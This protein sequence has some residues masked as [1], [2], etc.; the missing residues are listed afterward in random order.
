MNIDFSFIKTYCQVSPDDADNLVIDVPAT[1]LLDHTKTEQLLQRL[2]TLYQAHDLLLPVS[3]VGLSLFGLLGTQ[4]IILSQYKKSLHLPL[5]T[6]RLQVGLFNETTPFVSL[7]IQ[8]VIV[9]EP[10]NLVEYVHEQLATPIENIAAAGGVKSSLIYNQFSARAATLVEGFMQYETN[11]TAQTTCK[12]IYRE[13]KEDS[14]WRKNPFLHDPVFID[15]PYTPG[16]QMMMRSSCCMFYRR[17]NGVKCYNCP[18]LSAKE[19]EKIVQQ[20]N[21]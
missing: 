2:K 1:D 4:W 14:S 3:V 11:P 16:S 21:K 18:T 20:L 13:L 12:S 15:N 19:R 8:K 6:I 9:T 7:K 17:K 5:N 10:C